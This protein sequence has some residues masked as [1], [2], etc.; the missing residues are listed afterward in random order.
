MPIGALSTTTPSSGDVAGTSGPN[1]LKDI[2]A[3]IKASFPAFTT[4]Q[5]VCSLSGAQLSQ[6]SRKDANETVAGTW[7]FTARPTLVGIGFATLNDVQ[8][9]PYGQLYRSLDPDA[10]SGTVGAWSSS[11][12]GNGMTVDATLGRI[13]VPAAGVYEIALDGFAEVSSGNGAVDIR[14]NGSAIRVGAYTY[15]SG[16]RPVSAKVLATLAANDYIDLSWNGT[17]A[18]YSHYSLTVRRIA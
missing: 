2:K 16:T 5:D 1:E 11:V 18:G 8:A 14:K 10:F 17:L 3:Q 6:A 12:A 9:Q 13:T 15:A 7:N 4:G